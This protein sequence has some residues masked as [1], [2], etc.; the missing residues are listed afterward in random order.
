MVRVLTIGGDFWRLLHRFP[1]TWAPRPDLCSKRVQSEGH[2][3]IGVQNPYMV[4]CWALIPQWQSNCTL[5]VLGPYHSCSPVALG[6]VPHKARY[7]C[8]ALHLPQWPHE[9][10]NWGQIPS[11]CNPHKLYGPQSLLRVIHSLRW[12]SRSE[13]LQITFEP[14]YLAIAMP[15]SRC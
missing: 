10:Y 6:T 11:F 4:G 7:Y 3:G 9:P 13:E 2:I 12:A 5:W 1:Q 8:A 15:Q 14:Y